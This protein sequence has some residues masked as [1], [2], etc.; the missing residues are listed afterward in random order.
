MNNEKNHSITINR[1]FT[2]P[3]DIKNGLM[4]VKRLSKNSGALFCMKDEKIHH[5]WMKNTFVPLDLIFMDASFRVVG[6]IENTTPHDESLYFIKSASKYIIEIKNGYVK[7]NKIKKGDIINLVYK[8]TK[9]KYTARRVKKYRN[10][11]YTLRH[12]DV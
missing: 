5:F 8:L 12:R 1:K 9:K 3:K 6:T 4:H 2:S 7:R 11:Q 10:K